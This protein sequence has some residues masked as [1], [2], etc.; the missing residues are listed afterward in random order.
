MNRRCLSASAMAAVASGAGTEEDE[1][2][3]LECGA[4]ARRVH[5]VRRAGLAGLVPIAEVVEEI[6]VLVTRFLSTPPTSWWRVAREPDYQRADFARKLLTLAIDARF[7]DRALAVD[8]AEASTR[9]LDALPSNAPDVADLR[10]E[11]WKF[12]TA[13][14]R[15]AGR[16][17]RMAAAFVSAEDAARYSSDPELAHASILLSRALYLA[18][19]DIWQPEEAAALLERARRV[20]EARDPVRLR[21]ALTTGAL[22]SLRSGDLIAA[23]EVFQTVLA[24]TPPTDH[25]A[26]LDAL[27]NLAWARV[28]LRC[29][30]ADTEQ[31]VA[32]LIAAN[33]QIGRLVQ[34]ARAHWMMGRVHLIRGDCDDAVDFLELAAG[35]IGDR[36]SVIRI[37]L[38]TIEALL[39]AERFSD[40]YELAR[41]MASLAVELDQREP[42]RRRSLTAQVFAYLREAAD[43]QALT[44]DLVAEVARYL[45]RIRV[46]PPFEFVPP[47]PLTDM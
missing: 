6:D 23:R 28:E 18:E 2:H 27:S 5:L 13:I 7:R 24:L 21:A 1:R 42:S 16:Y 8:L 26:H 36:D 35:G 25:R 46:Q 37:G 44:A 15:E 43:R 12:S 19:P 33:A 38:D 14:L 39:L 34:L 9:I 41:D 40:A 22:L 20:F 11:A 4:C 45:D 29:A 31:V 3:A 47:M 17:G 30:D 10:F 32:A